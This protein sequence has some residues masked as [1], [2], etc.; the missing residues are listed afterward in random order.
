M[1]RVGGTAVFAGALVAQATVIA[2]FSFTK[3]S[4]LWYNLVGCALVI[5][6]ALAVQAM[7]AVCAAAD[8]AP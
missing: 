3:I 2:C 4:F 5:A 1:K 8:L 6:V 7:L